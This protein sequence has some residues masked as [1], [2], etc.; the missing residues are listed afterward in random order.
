[1]NGKF[2]HLFV[3][4]SVAA[5]AALPGAGFAAG[6]AASFSRQDVNAAG[7]MAQRV[8][9][10]Q[11]T[12][13]ASDGFVTAPYTVPNL[14]NA[15][16]LAASA[17][18]PWWVADNGTGTSTI[19]DGSGVPQ[20]LVVAVPGD[21][22]GAVF[23]PGTDFVVSDGSSSGAARF[24]FASEDGTISGWSSA[25]PPPAPSHNAF[26]VVDNSA[27]GAV[28]K[29]LAIASTASGDRLYAT[30][31]HNDRVDVFDG[32]FQ[33]VITPGAFV[34]RGIPRGY[35]PFGIRNINGRIF[36]TYAKQDADR[37]DDVAGQGFGFVS[38]FDTDG[39]FIARVATRGQLNSPWGIA[40]APPDFG[41]YGGHLLIGNFGDGNILAYKVTDDMRQF[42][43]AGQL[44]G[45]DGKNIVIEGLW[46]ISFGNGAA[47]GGTNELFF[48][49]GSD[50]EAHGAFGKVDVAVGF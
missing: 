1:M 30:D 20:A 31:F 47:A 18:G 11:E 16:G 45:R 39:T 33:A 10:Y 4:L 13:L 6:S 2:K 42:T 25:V 37:H 5:G 21:P 35:A 44:R 34:D 40:L 46:A 26:V 41:R 29:G 12:Y 19:Y 48:T 3:F 36:V 17:T 38:A 8:G 49:A 9:V 22:T 28:Y 14:V 50:H 43:P 7:S 15:W 27:A 32:S 23:S 24:L